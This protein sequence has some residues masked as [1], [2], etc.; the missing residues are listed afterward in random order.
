VTSIVLNNSSSELPSFRPGLRERQREARDEAI[1]AAA[2]ALLAEK[3]FEALTMEAVAERVGISRQTLYHHFRSKDELVL[4]AVLTLVEKGILEI[5][6]LDASLPPLARLDR[7]VHW[8]IELRL[9]PG[10]AAI[11]KARPAL[12]PIKAHPDYKRVF[13]RRVSVI[14]AIVDAGQADGSITPSIPSLL[15]VHSLLA[16]VCDIRYDELVE[17]PEVTAKSLVDNV[18]QLFVDGIRSRS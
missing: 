15:I 10:P 14:R 9:A 7:I 11:A 12:L 16:L 3:G 1:L 4:R 8:M 13:D 5:E 17:M 18:A 2:F 6:Q